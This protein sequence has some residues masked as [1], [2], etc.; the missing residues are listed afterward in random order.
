VRTVVLG[1]LYA[2]LGDGLRD[3]VAARLAA[4]VGPVQVRLARPD[5]GG[6][7]RGAAAWVVRELLRQP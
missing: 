1:G 3:A 4:R 6:S 5:S 7:L 2:Q